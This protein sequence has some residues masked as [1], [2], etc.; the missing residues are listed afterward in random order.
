MPEANLKLLVATRNPG[1]IVELNSLFES[2]PLR[3]LSLANV[4]I[5]TDVEETG[6]TFV[7][8]AILKARAYAMESGIMA[9]ADDS[10]LEVECLGNAPGV[11]S[12]RFAGKSA[13]NDERIAKLLRKLD[14]VALNERNARFVCVMAVS[15]SSG[16]ILHEA[17]GVCPGRIGFEPKGTNGF[18]YD[19]V[20][21]PHGFNETFGELGD[22]IKQQI[23]HR[24][25]ASAAIIRFLRDFIAI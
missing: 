24:A 18:G 7:E 10:G 17:Q 13:A 5:E 15:D 25:R 16:K 20:F 1:K 3:L 14:G 4:E 19:P 23:S 11:Y 22:D 12:A 21:I 9:L 6:S 2:L 8:N